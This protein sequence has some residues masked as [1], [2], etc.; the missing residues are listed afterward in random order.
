[1][2][3]PKYAPIEAA[4]RHY[5]SIFEIILQVGSKVPMSFGRGRQFNGFISSSCFEA[6]PAAGDQGHEDAPESVEEN[7]G[8][9]ESRHTSV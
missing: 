5:R 1:M 2:R 8:T 9:V 3:V 6:I 4:G 7:N